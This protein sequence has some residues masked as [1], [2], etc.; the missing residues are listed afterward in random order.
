MDGKAVAV[1]VVAAVVHYLISFRS[2]LHHY[3]LVMM[4]SS[5]YRRR[6]RHVYFRGEVML[7]FV[8]STVDDG[9]QGPLTSFQ[10]EMEEVVN[11]LQQLICRTLPTKDIIHR[12]I[13]WNEILGIDI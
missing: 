3:H 7:V 6:R 10:V 13:R 2:P 4:I 12:G 8:Y 1:V 9:S 11:L 5:S